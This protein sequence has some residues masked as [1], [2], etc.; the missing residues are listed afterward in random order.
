MMSA[1]QRYLLSS[2]VVSGVTAIAVVSLLVSTGLPLVAMAGFAV[3]S[4][5]AFLVPLIYR[6]R[7]KLLLVPVA[8][9]G[10]TSVAIAVYLV[11]KGLPALPVVA[12]TMF[13]LLV[14]GA[15]LGL[16]FL[17]S[18]DR[19]VVDERDHQILRKATM[20][21]FGVFWVLFILTSV[22]IPFLIG[23]DA[24]IPCLYLLPVPWTSA[25]IL[26]V[27]RASA[28]LLLYRIAG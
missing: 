24:S 14:I 6:S 20:I 10:V 25:W 9:A 22:L 19:P 12:L 23:F 2:L 1:A 13:S 11:A 5:E 16:C 4:A 18:A 27:T 3:M 15:L 26:Y 21:G 28:G 17:G 7:N 8:L